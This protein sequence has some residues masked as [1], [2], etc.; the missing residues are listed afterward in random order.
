MS[1]LIVSVSPHIKDNTDTTSIMAVKEDERFPAIRECL[2]GANCGACGYAG[3]DGYARALLT[4]DVKSNLCVPGADGTAKKLSELL[5][6]ACEDV[7]E[8][9][10]FLQC[11]G[12]CNATA[13]KMDY[14]GI[15]SC[16][17]AKLL[18]GGTG[19]CSFGCLGYGDCVK[20]CPYGA[21]SIQNG[22]AHAVAN[23]NARDKRNQLADGLLIDI[24]DHHFVSQFRKLNRQVSTKP[25][26]SN[27]QH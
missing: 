13:A 1:K 16:S 2:P 19:K 14:H 12:D 8:Q 21:L 23:L 5:G 20:T 4:G 17:A 25:P 15:E 26:G 18:F 6:V 24:H 10:A 3:C 11:S 9:V 27:D 22:I 7:T